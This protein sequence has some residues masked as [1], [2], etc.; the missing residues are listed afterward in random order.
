MGKIFA[1]EG[2]KGTGKTTLLNNLKII[3]P[4]LECIEGFK[5]DNNLDLNIE[6]EFYKNQN[7]Y[8]EKKIS[9][10]KKFLKSSK[11][12]LITRGVENIK[13][14]T[15]RYPKIYN[16]DWEVEKNLKQELEILES[17]RSDLIIYLNANDE[18]IKKRVFNDMNK[19]RDNIDKY[20]E[21]WGKEIRNWYNEYKNLR[22]IETENK[23]SLEVAEEVKRILIELEE[24]C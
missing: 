1:L 16:Y 5:L 20:L 7:I 23:T 3:Y 12:A 8:I 15:E 10:Y 18:T 24:K 22:I 11:N 2:L 14:F 4:K 19:R 13:K 9:Q 21:V 17:Y 6:K